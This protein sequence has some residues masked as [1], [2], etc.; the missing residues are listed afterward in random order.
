MF[1]RT[2]GRSEEFTVLIYIL[3]ERANVVKRVACMGTIV[4]RKE[5]I[6]LL[7]NYKVI[8]IIEL[9]MTAFC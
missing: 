1:S 8:T 2:S 3:Y 6:L 5:I 9:Y 4:H 7:P